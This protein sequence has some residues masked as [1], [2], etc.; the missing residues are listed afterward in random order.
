MAIES[1]T[2]DPE[3]S[4]GVNSGGDSDDGDFAK[5]DDP[6]STQMAPSFGGRFL[7]FAGTAIIITAIVFSTIAWEEP[8]VLIGCLVIGLA[9]GAMHYK[10]RK[11]A[12][13]KY[14]ASILGGILGGVIS[15]AALILLMLMFFAMFVD[16]CQGVLGL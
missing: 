15:S 6:Q 12:P 13:G 3:K 4:I 2:R 9:G 14:G 1:D 10:G 11:L 16:G 5:S 8:G 7:R